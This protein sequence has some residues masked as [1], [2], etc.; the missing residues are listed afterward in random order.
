MQWSTDCT[1]PSTTG[2]PHGN[3][4]NTAP[5]ADKYLPF[6][7]SIHKENVMHSKNQ[8]WIVERQLEVLVIEP[9]SPEETWHSSSKS[10]SLFSSNEMIIRFT[11]P[12][13]KIKVRRDFKSDKRI[14]VM[15]IWTESFLQ[16]GAGGANHLEITDRN[17]QWHST[18][19]WAEVNFLEMSFPFN[20]L[21]VLMNWTKTFTSFFVSPSAH[22][23]GHLVDVPM[24]GRG[25]ITERFSSCS[26]TQLSG[27][28]EWIWFISIW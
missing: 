1:L 10:L 9:R 21:Q 28:A 5:A 13:A 15:L 11:V 2:Q 26:R 19:W 17:F 20:S 25:C 12:K 14:K 24:F 7:S 16:S 4:C 27:E 23:W 22:L 6:T 18:D 3:N 8:V